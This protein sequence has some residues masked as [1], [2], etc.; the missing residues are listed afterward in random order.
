MEFDMELK[1]MDSSRKLTVVVWGMLCALSL[2]AGE[3]VP[4]VDGWSGA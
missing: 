1:K 2:G 4:S 3:I